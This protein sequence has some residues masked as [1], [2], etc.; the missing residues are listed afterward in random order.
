MTE[1]VCEKTQTPMKIA[2]MDFPACQTGGHSTLTKKLFTYEK[3]TF[4][5]SP[6]I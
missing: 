4:I 1:H 6:G 2:N 3:C 5:F